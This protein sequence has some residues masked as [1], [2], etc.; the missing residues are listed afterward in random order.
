MSFLFQNEKVKDL[1]NTY[2]IK[3]IYDKDVN[4]LKEYTEELF[5]SETEELC[6]G[7]MDFFIDDKEFKS[8]GWK[9]W[10]GLVINNITNLDKEIK[11]LKEDLRINTENL[12]KEIKHDKEN[13]QN[14]I[15]NLEELKRIS[16]KIGDLRED[17]KDI[18]KCYENIDEDITN[19]K[20]KSSIWGALSG[21]ISAGIAALLYKIIR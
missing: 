3:N 18:K 19:L 9:Y 13:I 6:G 14:I 10:A 17:L 11:L 1:S 4:Y 2:I 7:E 8:S 16:D 20:I 5:Q 21:A 12:Y 15:V